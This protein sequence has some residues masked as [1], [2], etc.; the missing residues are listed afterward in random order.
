MDSSFTRVHRTF[1]ALNSIS[2]ALEST[3]NAF[4]LTFIALKLTSNALNL[5]FS[6]LNLESSAIELDASAI[7]LKSTALHPPS[8]AFN[9]SFKDVQ[10]A[11]RPFLPPLSRLRGFARVFRR[12]PRN[13]SSHTLVDDGAPR[14]RLI[15]TTHHLRTSVSICG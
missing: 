1:T 5:D 2:T 11:L 13:Q 4:P 10:G 15:Q 7:E 9:P 8:N 6:G 3:S 14:C 12:L